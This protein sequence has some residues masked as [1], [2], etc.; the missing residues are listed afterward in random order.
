MPG[1]RGKT[2][3]FA[4]P[5]DLS[6]A[7]LLEMSV[8]AWVVFSVICMLFG[9]SYH[10]SSVE[11]WTFITLGSV[12]LL[13]VIYQSGRQAPVNRG[14]MIIA[15]WLLVSVI[16]GTWVGFFSYECCIGEYWMAEQLEARQNVLPSEP[17]GA[18]ANAGELVFA[19]E[20]RVDPSKS[21][22]YKDTSVFCVAPIAS[23]SP[24][25]TVQFWAA[26]VDCC[27]ARGSFVCDDAWNPKAHAG[28]IIRNGTW[29]MFHEDIHSQY[30]KAVKLA[31]VTYGIASVEEPIFLRWVANPSQ[32]ELNIW[33][34]GLGVL[35]AAVIISALLCGLQGCA[36]HVVL[37]RSSRG[38]I[39]NRLA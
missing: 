25:E 18:Y 31:E 30:M 26:G 21:V 8:I 7:Q 34:A 16:L 13:G 2:D 37:N 22:G 38:D 3:K 32:V 28:V 11:I 23:D 1:D 36:I 6:L 10:N 15:T 35:L 14:T 27:G 17:A 24:M 9:L 5:P 33:R 39:R 4:P 29:S 12:V 20:A 19:E